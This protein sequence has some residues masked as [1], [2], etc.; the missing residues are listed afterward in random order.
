[1]TEDDR[2]EDN[3]ATVTSLRDLSYLCH[4]WDEWNHSQPEWTKWRKGVV[5]DASEEARYER[6]MSAWKERETNSSGS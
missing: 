3:L 2:L 4:L 5:W 1:M 6:D